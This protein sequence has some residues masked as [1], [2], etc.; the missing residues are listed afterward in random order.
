MVVCSWFRLNNMILYGSKDEI[1]YSRGCYKFQKK[2]YTNIVVVLQGS[3]GCEEAKFRGFSRVFSKAH[4]KNPRY[5]YYL[6]KREKQN[7]K[8]QKFW[9][10]FIF[11]FF[12][13]QLG[14]LQSRPRL[15]RVFKFQGF[16]RKQGVSLNPG[17][18][19]YKLLTWKQ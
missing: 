19:F 9:F 7:W 11:F 1:T 14:I 4:N 17:F 5:I 3:H 2:I 18:T 6:K 13:G 15:S 12:Q 10:C 8:Q 16:S